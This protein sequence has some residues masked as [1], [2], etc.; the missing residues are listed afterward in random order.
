MRP[1]TLGVIAITSTL[2]FAC[3]MTETTTAENQPPA[4]TAAP[5]SWRTKLAISKR[6]HNSS[7]LG[8]LDR[9]K[10]PAG[11]GN[12]KSGGACGLSTGDATCDTCLDASCCAQNTA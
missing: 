10:V 1:M 3:T 12:L 9:K 8:V 4:S 11:P 2:T 5:Q 7:A 6:V